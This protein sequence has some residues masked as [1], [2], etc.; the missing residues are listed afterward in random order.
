MG[1]LGPMSLIVDC[2]GLPTIFSVVRLPKGP[3][4][5]HD[6]R[7]KPVAIVRISLQV[8]VDYIIIILAKKVPT[9][10]PQ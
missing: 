5:E 7:I 9:D 1:H 10:E 8:S 4:L 2:P 6:I 3:R